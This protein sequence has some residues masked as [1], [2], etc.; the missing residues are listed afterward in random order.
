MSDSQTQSLTRRHFFKASTGAALISCFPVSA[1][2]AP[3]DL[4]AA[5]KHLFGDR[6]INSGKVSL[7]IPAISENG[8]SVPI[9]VSVDHPINDTDY[10]KRI[11]ILSERNPIAN[12]STYHLTPHSGLA[13][14][15]SRIRLSGSQTVTAIAE[16]NDGTLWSA[17]AHTV[18]TLA[19]CVLH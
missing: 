5:Q 1:T 19:A 16:L 9:T 2:A 13:K 14:V 3:D 17:S 12:I 11:A 10:V 6:P 7:Q 18:V 4:L 8:Y 15:Q